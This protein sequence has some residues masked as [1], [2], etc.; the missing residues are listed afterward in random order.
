LTAVALALALGLFVVGA[1]GAI[2]F[3]NA[4]RMRQLTQDVQQALAGA[5]TAIEARD[6]A[7]ARQRVAEAQGRLG[8]ER[9]N[10]PGLAADIDR[11]REEIEERQADEGRYR[12]FL[13]MAN[14]AHSVGHLTAESHEDRMAKFEKLLSMYGVLAEDNWVSRLET[15][16]LTAAQKQQ[17]REMAYLTLLYL[18]DYKVR[19]LKEDPR[20][21]PASL[22]LLERGQ[23]FHPPTRAFYF[24]RSMC[25]HRQGNTAAEKEDVKRFKATAAQTAWDYFLPGHTASWRGDLEEA[26]RSYRKALAVQPN[27]YNSLFF[28]ARGLGSRRLR[29]LEGDYVL[30][31]HHPSQNKTADKG[32]GLRLALPLDLLPA[33]VPF[34]PGA[35]DYQRVVEDAHRTPGA[36][37]CG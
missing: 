30:H 29:R 1:L 14:D 17:V 37:S 36:S 28:L 5:R 16:Y 32:S 7:L 21:V 31:Q 13:E 33:S 2:Y 3:Q 10:L 22:K 20:S 12:Q 34:H 4:G 27:H 11:T 6:L 23:A 8:A 15:T 9:A 35:R 19:W 25:Y 26:I 18:A 24:V